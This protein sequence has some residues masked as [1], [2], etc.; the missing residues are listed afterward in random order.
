MLHDCCDTLERVDTAI[1][2]YTESMTLCLIGP[3]PQVSRCL[4]PQTLFL[5]FFASEPACRS[6]V[7]PLQ[8]QETWALLWDWQIGSFELA[9]TDPKLGCTRLTSE[10]LV[11][12][13]F[14]SLCDF[15][16]DMLKTATARKCHSAIFFLCL[17]WLP[18]PKLTTSYARYLLSYNY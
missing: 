18:R 1:S 6:A 3:C 9:T 4:C 12:S 10:T 2:S 8:H 11:L 15:K 17:L 14:R 5:S 13:F 16:F 7:F